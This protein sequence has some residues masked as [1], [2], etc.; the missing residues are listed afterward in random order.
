MIKVGF[1]KELK[2]G[3]M[4]IVPGHERGPLRLGAAAVGRLAATAER[5]PDRLLRRLI[6]TRKPRGKN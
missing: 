3:E 4:I 2:S 5:K 1:L 6:A